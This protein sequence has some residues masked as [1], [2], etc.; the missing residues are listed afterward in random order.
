MSY[1]YVSN[2]CF[3]QVVRKKLLLSL[4]KIYFLLY[5][6]KVSVLALR[7]LSGTVPS[8]VLVNAATSLKQFAKLCGNP[9]SAHSFNHRTFK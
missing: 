8:Q 4:I 3:I 7:E 5:I 9:N 1:F 6:F 2:A